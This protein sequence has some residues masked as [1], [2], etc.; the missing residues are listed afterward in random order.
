M[1]IKQEE[2]GLTDRQMKLFIE[3]HV[4]ADFFIRQ[5]MYDRVQS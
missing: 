3:L 1:K 5:V 2:H 4:A